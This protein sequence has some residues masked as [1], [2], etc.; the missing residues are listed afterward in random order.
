MK[1]F[2]ALCLGVLALARPAMAQDLDLICKG[3][4]RGMFTERAGGVVMADNQG[5]AVS[6]RGSSA[7]YREVPT[8]A[9]FRLEGEAAQLNL[10]QPP[11]CSICV[12]ER[13]WRKVKNL[14]V[15]PDRIAGKITY[16]LFSGTSFEIDRRTG[17]MTSSN[18]F[19]GECEAQDLSERKF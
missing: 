4:M 9:Q 16:G 3:A 2:A 13:G 7:T 1:R 18:G 12:G 8:L 10:P 17:I 15:G 19:R 14:E 6:G 5:N 11:T